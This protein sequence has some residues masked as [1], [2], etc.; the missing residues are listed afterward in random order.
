MGDAHAGLGLQWVWFAWIW[1][2]LMGD[3]FL[4]P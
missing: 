2:S 1:L 3:D 4:S